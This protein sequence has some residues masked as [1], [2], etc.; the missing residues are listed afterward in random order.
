MR[1]THQPSIANVPPPVFN[2]QIMGPQSSMTPSEED[3]ELLC[4][5]HYFY[6]CHR[7][8]FRRLLCFQMT[9]LCRIEYLHPDLPVSYLTLQ[10][11]NIHPGFSVV[12]RQGS[13]S[14]KPAGKISYDIGIRYM[15]VSQCRTVSTRHSPSIAITQRRWL[16]LKL[17]NSF[18]GLL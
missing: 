14:L 9:S 6:S 18:Q 16:F 3:D 2:C 11:Y 17:S 12:R 15:M 10:E 5:V 13:L 1:K 8:A 4:P 7:Q